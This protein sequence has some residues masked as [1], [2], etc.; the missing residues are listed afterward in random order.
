MQIVLIIIGILVTAFVVYGLI[1]RAK[2]KNTPMESD[3]EKIVT[4]SDKN[5]KH[6]TADRLMLVDFWAEWCAPC[7][8]MVPVLNELAGEL[9]SGVGIGKVD[10]EQNQS[11][12]Q[13]YRV[14][15]IPT[16]IL[17]KNGVEVNRF[18]GVKNK[19]FLLKQIQ[20]V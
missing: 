10:I 18:V 3:H 9:G 19:N 11:L 8:M 16:M 14:R 20:K 1:L 7:R 2:L 13:K 15:S 4:L 5:F 12:A 17:L 6:Q